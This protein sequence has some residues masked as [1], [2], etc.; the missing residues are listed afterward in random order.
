VL[1]VLLSMFIL[2]AAAGV[3][4]P[5]RGEATFREMLIRDCLIKQAERGCGCVFYRVAY[6]NRCGDVSSRCRR[7]APGG[8]R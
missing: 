1:A 2:I 4:C 7:R 3:F 5:I 8:C 6:I